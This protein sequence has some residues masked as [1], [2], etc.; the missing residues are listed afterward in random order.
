[1]GRKRIKE[2]YFTEKEEQAV[3]SYNNTDSK[4]EKDYIYRTFLERPFRIMVE[5]ILRRYSTHIGNYDIHEIEAN[6]LSHLIE[7]MVKYDPNKVLPSGAKP[8]AFSYCQTII[9]NFYIDH[10]IKSYAEKTNNLLFDDYSDEILN[11]DEHI[12]YIDDDKSDIDLL[13]DKIIFNIEEMIEN[14]NSLKPN[15]IS[16]GYA[17]IN[18]FK[19]WNVLFLEESPEGNYEKKITNKY[20]K[21][22]ILIF[23]KEQTN[24]NTKEIRQSLKAFKDLYFMEKNNYLN[25]Y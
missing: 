11:K 16:V 12:Y 25:D 1:M 23:L 10:G 18:I 22:K 7:Q 5:S 8:R 24:L 9:R 3:I 4:T 15:E 21:N 19:N 20:T 2:Y 6:A 13:I 17:I 14:D